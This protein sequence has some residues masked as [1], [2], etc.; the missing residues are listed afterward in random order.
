[1]K[2]PK[3]KATRTRKSQ[4]KKK[5]FLSLSPRSG[6]RTKIPSRRWLKIQLKA[7]TK[8]IL[9]LKLSL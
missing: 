6:L 2:G 9:G 4:K 1:L 5:V 3:K 7:M 8:T